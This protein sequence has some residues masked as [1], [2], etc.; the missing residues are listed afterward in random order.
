M[1]VQPR[2]RPGLFIGAKEMVVSLSKDKQ[3]LAQDI[4]GLV[5][6][7]NQ[8]HERSITAVHVDVQMVG[9]ACIED[10]RPVY[11]VGVVDVV[12]TA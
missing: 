4:R 2:L 8:H 10:G 6:A 12:V 7:F 5:V 1:S 3:Q 11:E 9:V